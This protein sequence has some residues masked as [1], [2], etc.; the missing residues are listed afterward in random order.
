MSASEKPT[1]TDVKIDNGSAG[2]LMWL[3]IRIV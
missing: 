1:K 3:A 2:G